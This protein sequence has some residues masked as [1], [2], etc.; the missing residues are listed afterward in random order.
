MRTRYAVSVAIAVVVGVGAACSDSPTGALPG[1]GTM[2]AMIGD[3]LK[4]SANIGLN[5]R[6]TEDSVLEIEGVGRAR[7][8]DAQIVSL[9]KLSIRQVVI[10]TLAVELDRVFTFTFAN[11]V[12]AGYAF[13]SEGGGDDFATDNPGGSGRVT[14]TRLTATHAEGTFSFTAPRDEGFDAVRRLALGKFS[15][16]LQ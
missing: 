8:P 13:Y 1:G 11:T 16:R 12:V 4:W 7:G 9:V 15:V 3:T 14:I 5:A 6:I 10:D 2:T